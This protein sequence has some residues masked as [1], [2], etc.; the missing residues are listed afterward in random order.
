MFGSV[1][2]KSRPLRLT[3]LV[4]P[5]EPKQ[6]REAIRLSS[7]L[8]G[9]ST[10]PIV[11]VYKQMPPTWKD[12]PLPAP[13]ARHVISGYVEAFD[14]D[15][16]VQY[17]KSVPD[18]VRKTGRKII[19]PDDVWGDPALERR[20]P[21]RLGIGIFEILDDVFEKHFRFRAKYPVRIVVP[22]LPSSLSLFWASVFGEFPENL[23][24]LVV[25]RY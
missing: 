2:I 22:R 9:G 12:K 1:E 14:P 20:L 8:W 18:F 13:S 24:E 6:V 5:N 11:P 25:K 3:Y 19:G 21:R 4:D 7:A 16:I 23:A 15:I 10:F 17:S